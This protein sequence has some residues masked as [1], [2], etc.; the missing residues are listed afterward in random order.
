[1]T[2]PRP[3]IYVLAAVAMLGAVVAEAVGFYSRGAL[4]ANEGKVLFG[5]LCVIFGWRFIYLAVLKRW[6]AGEELRR[7]A[8]QRE[9]ERGPRLWRSVIINGV[10][11]WMPQG[12]S[13]KDFI[14]MRDKANAAAPEG[15]TANATPTKETPSRG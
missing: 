10:P 14:P 12:G 3:A 11:G 6:E 13:A 7:L 1:M 9:L 5:A 15:T 2:R 8:N 4:M